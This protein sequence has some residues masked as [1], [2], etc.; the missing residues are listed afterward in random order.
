MIKTHHSVSEQSNLRHRHIALCAITWLLTAACLTTTASHA[1]NRVDVGM[2]VGE[3]EYHGWRCGSPAPAA[4]DAELIQFALNTYDHCGD[5]SIAEN[6]GWATTQNPQQQ[7]CGPSTHWYPDFLYGIEEK[8]VRRLVVTYCDGIHD[9]YTNRRIRDIACPS[10]YTRSGSKCVPSGINKQKSLGECRDGEP[11][12]GNPISIATGNNFIREVDYS[13]PPNVPDLIRYYNSASSRENARIGMRWRHNFSHYLAR[14][15]N[16]TIDGIHMYRPDGKVYPFSKNASGDWESDSDVALSLTDISGGYEVISEDG[17]IEVYDDAGFLTSITSPQGFTT[18]LEYMDDGDFETLDR[19]TGPFGHELQLFYNDDFLVERIELPGGEEITYEY[20]ESGAK[21]GN[22]KR[23]YYPHETLIPPNSPY[24]EYLYENTNWPR[25]VTKILDENGDPYATWTY[26][27]AGRAATSKHGTDADLTTLQYASGS[28]T[29]T[30]TIDTGKTQQQVVTFQNVAGVNKTHG[31][32]GDLCTECGLSA[33]TEYDSNGYVSS[34][35]D[36]AGNKTLFGRDGKGRELCRLEGISTITSSKNRPRRIEKVWHPTYSAVEEER[37]YEVEAGGSPDLTECD[38]QDDTDWE[39]RRETITTYQTGSARVSTRT[40]RSYKDG[41]QDEDPRVTTYTYYGPSDNDGLE[42]QLATIDGPLPNTVSPAFADI[43]TFKYAI[44]T[45]ANHTAG[46]LIEII[47]AK[48]HITSIESHDAHGRPTTIKDP[49]DSI[50]VLTYHPRGWLH[51]RTVD[52]NDPTVY[53]RDAAGLLDKVTSPTGAF[54]DFD[55]DEAHRLIKIADNDGNYVDYDLD[56]AGNRRAENIYDSTATLQRTVSQVFNSLSQLEQLIEEPSVT[57]QNITRFTYDNNGNIERTIDPRDTAPLAT[58]DIDT[59]NTYDALDRVIS[60]EARDDGTTMM[61]YDVFDNV[62]FVSDPEGTE[63]TYEYNGFSELK[64]LMSPD[65]GHNSAS[66][67]SPPQSVEAITYTYDEAGNVKTY[68]DARA[69]TTIYSYDELSRLTKVDYPNDT[70]I[71]YTYDEDG[72]GENGIGRLTTMND[73]SGT[74]KYTYDLRGNMLT[75]TYIQAV[76]GSLATA[77]QYNDADQVEEITYPSGLRVVYHYDSVGRVDNITAVLPDLTNIDIVRDVD[78]APFGGVTFLEFGNGTPTNGVTETWTY[79][80]AGRVESIVPSLPILR[81]LSY[82][83]DAANNIETEDRSYDPGSGT[84]NATRSF[85]YDNESRLKWQHDDE[86]AWGE[87][88]GYDQNGNRLAFAPDPSGTKP[89]PVPYYTTIPGTNRIDK[90]DGSGAPAGWFTYDASGNF[91]VNSALSPEMALYYDESGRR[92]YTDFAPGDT[93]SYGT[94]WDRTT[95]YNG[96]G[97]RTLLSYASNFNFTYQYGSAGQLLSM[98]AHYSAT[99]NFYEEY[100]WLGDRMVA[101]VMTDATTDVSSLGFTHVN[102]VGLLLAM[103]NLAGQP[104]Y[105]AEQISAFG[106]AIVLDSDPDGDSIDESPSLIGFPG[107]I[108]DPILT[109]D[110][111]YNYYRDYVAWTSRYLQSDPIGLFGGMNTYSYA[112]NNPLGV[113]DMLGLDPECIFMFTR[114]LDEFSRIVEDEVWSGRVRIPGASPPT[115][116]SCAPSTPSFGGRLGRAIASTPPCLP[117][118]LSG[119]NGAVYAYLII[120]E[121]RRDYR[122]NV[123]HYY[124]CRD[125]E[126]SEWKWERKFE[127]DILVDSDELGLR[128]RFDLRQP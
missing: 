75:K 18:T 28:T 15:T 77:Y 128:Y 101:R 19:V 9:G 104:S 110:V 55:Y 117:P 123:V 38:P 94:D 66:G 71:V 44:A 8:N 5:A 114:T 39:L 122:K 33:S 29:V 89:A 40:V 112:L 56:Q 24:R 92:A 57:V 70:D 20:H 52:G 87:S 10:G 116:A 14:V 115:A 1:A 108:A 43:T 65:A 59:V 72:N 23:V 90:D 102:Q 2:E 11:T 79:D 68:T 67:Q 99:R 47:N 4:T 125:S 27:S 109:G 32:T 103:T 17:E 42:N 26:D 105:L 106:P 54:V 124:R 25:A 58:A 76:L 49:N 63:T 41:S 127:K 83:Y 120:L 86:Y 85:E 64:T 50:T 21:E 22:L 91:I 48:G 111:Y 96:Q 93:T 13:S 118:A 3:W 53:S 95:A 113:I 74:T 107:Q 31:V 97:E 35:T 36:A 46:D 34:R 84:V 6:W 81:E 100:I 37:I 61:E 119:S 60:I 16:S 62:V 80:Q 98:A 126:C 7:G 73:E 88:S 30:R 51:T 121:A 82:G 45:D 12:A 69:I 78:Y